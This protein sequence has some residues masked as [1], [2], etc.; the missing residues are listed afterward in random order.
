MEEIILFA[1]IHDIFGIKLMSSI[2]DTC[3]KMIYY[4]GSD[5]NQ[6]HLFSLLDTIQP[7]DEKDKLKESL[8]NI[9]RLS[10]SMES[11]EL[12]KNKK[13]SLW[14]YD[15]IYFSTDT[16][17]QEILYYNTEQMNRLEYI[18]ENYECKEINY[19]SS[20]YSYYHHGYRD[21]NSDIFLYV[22]EINEAY[23]VQLGKEKNISTKIYRTPILYCQRDG[24]QYL[25][26][27][28]ILSH[29]IQEYV[30]WV[31]SRIPNYF[32][33]N[34]I[35]IP[36]TLDGDIYSLS[37]ETVIAKIIEMYH[38]AKD[39]LYEIYSII[40][41]K[42]ISV[43]DIMNNIFTNQY[44]IKV[45][46]ANVEEKLNSIDAIFYKI[47]QY[48]FP[49]LWM[50]EGEGKSCVCKNDEISTCFNRVEV[51]FAP[52]EKIVY[53][54]NGKELEYYTAG[55]GETIVIVN[56][57]GVDADAWTKLIIMLSADYRVVYWNTR[58]IYDAQKPDGSREYICGV[59]DQV[60]D[61]EAI[62]NNEGLDKIHIMSWCS[63]A[64]A[65]LFY[66]TK[67][68]DKVLSQIFVCGEFAPFEGSKPY[69]S[70]FRENIQLIAEII[71][72]DKKMLDF[73]MKIIHSGMFNRPIKEYDIANQNYIFEVMPEKHRDC[74]L[75]PFKLKE[76]MVNFLNLCIEYYSHD[77]TELLGMVS[78][79]TL[80]I[81]AECDQ[82]AP[83]MQ[84][85]WVYSKT[86]DSIFICFPAA[87]HLL[88]LERTKDVYEIIEQHM[89]YSRFGSRNDC[90]K[91]R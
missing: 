60:A 76:T 14:I 43:L 22:R 5:E 28:N 69:H 47:Y 85:K 13:V 21:E 42:K 67:H 78:I 19:M 7:I 6:K 8:H 45:Q 73:Y 70:K 54:D 40:G 37:V 34:S 39:T 56:A 51:E 38:A 49:R 27:E 79:P 81:S 30:L 26:F 80:L 23:L 17:E 82:V 59:D 88:I 87:S 63:G 12:L 64:K 55:E 2:K 35:H 4:I 9:I 44:K 46:V 33:E 1:R 18:A 20:Y 77:I 36:K 48:H 3:K 91:D 86:S 71:R 10:G 62:I 29:R 83:H 15:D 68:P 57:Y 74:L 66:Y 61:I 52:S 24:A 75:A 90:F 58:G 53:L 16:Y 84:S 32:K 41:D 11:L 25:S 50:K 65:A 31:E 72:N 89:K